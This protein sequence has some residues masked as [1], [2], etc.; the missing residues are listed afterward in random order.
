[1]QN[2][3]RVAEGC[4]QILLQL[5]NGIVFL[6]TGIEKYKAQNQRW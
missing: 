2:I 5:Y 1:M 4:L 3:F 6:E